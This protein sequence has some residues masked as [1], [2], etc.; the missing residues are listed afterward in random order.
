MVTPKKESRQNLIR[1]FAITIFVL[2][3]YDLLTYVTIP[4]VNPRQ[5]VLLSNNSTLTMISLLSGGGFQN[6]SLMSMGVSS[7]VSSQIIVQ[8]LQSNVVSTFTDWSKQGEIGRRKLGQLVRSFTVILGLVQSVGIISGINT[9]TNY[10]FVLINSWWNYLVIGF[11]LTAGTFIAMWLGDQ[12]TQYGLGNGISV[13]IAAGIVKQLPKS[14][15]SF[16][17]NVSD[18]AGTSWDKIF[19]VCFLLI[20]LVVFITWFNRSEYRVPIQY[21]R[22]I[23]Q[24]SPYSYLPLKIIVPSVVPVIFSNSILM[25]PQTFLMFFQNDQKNNWFRVVNNIFSLSTTTGIVLYIILI[26]FFTY[27]YSLIQVDPNILADN[28]SRQGAYIPGVWPGE[29]T[30]IYLRNLLYDLDLPGSI[31]LTT[32]SVIPIIL[33]NSISP[34]LRTGLSGSSLLIVIGV[35]TDI[36]RQIEGLKFKENNPKILNAEYEI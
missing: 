9:L 20:S 4:G 16:I 6:F 17:L 26:I 25:I 27:L 5:L 19:F 33:S 36:G 30:A 22:R 3:I 7:Y 21:T 23:S 14:V 28:L 1:R 29:P 2:I 12:I 32:I 15:K 11:L 8:L 10:G 18:T 24:T 31:F 34:N 13:I 35:L